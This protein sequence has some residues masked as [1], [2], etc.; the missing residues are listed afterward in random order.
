[1]LILCCSSLFHYLT[2]ISV[3]YFKYSTLT[4]VHRF[5]S[6][7]L[8]LINTYIVVSKRKPHINDTML[9]TQ[10]DAQDLKTLTRNGQLVAISAQNLMQET[11]NALNT[12]SLITFDRISKGSLIEDDEFRVK[13]LGHPTFIS[14]VPKGRLALPLF[15]SRKFT[16]FPEYDASL[17][18][19]VQLSPPPCD[20][21]CKTYPPDV[22]DQFDCFRRCLKM[23]RNIENDYDSCFRPVVRIFVNF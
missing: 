15:I 22:T 21:N 1:M 12:G 2:L 18:V 5:N 9:D 19:Y 3:D 4:S 10:F 11:D 23:L 14:R 7:N 17:D 20:T 6:E 8:V 13:N 16:P